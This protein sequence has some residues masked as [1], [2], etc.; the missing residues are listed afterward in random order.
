LFSEVPL[1]GLSQWE[2][3]GQERKKREENDFRLKEGREG[4]SVRMKSS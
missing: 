4:W 3:R 1:P 2:R